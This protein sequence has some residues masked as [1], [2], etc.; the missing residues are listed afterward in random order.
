MIGNFWKVILLLSKII[1]LL[2][3][4]LLYVL[5]FHSVTINGILMISIKLIVWMTISLLSQLSMM[6]IPSYPLLLSLLSISN[7]LHW[8]RN[9]KKK[10]LK[11]SPRTKQVVMMVCHKM[12]R[13]SLNLFQSHYVFL[14]NRS[15]DE[16][17]FLNIWKIANVIPI[18]IKGDKPQP[19]NY[20]PV[21]LLSCIGKLQE[22]I[23]FKK[24]TCI[25]IY[26]TIIFYTS[27]N[28]ASY[29][30]T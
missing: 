9:R 2:L 4:F 11:F 10:Q 16:G 26:L 3:L 30:T 6:K 20:I 27:I 22:R 29:L 17:I 1:I 28:L 25:I 23:V 21:T 14:M 12:L 18:F 13:V 15:F 19:S 5:H 24:K 7:N 8:T